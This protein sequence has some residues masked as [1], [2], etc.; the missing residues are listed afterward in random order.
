MT[1]R[2]FYYR[3]TQGIRVTVK[4]SY[5][6]SES[7]PDLGRYV[8][9]YHVRIENVSRHTVQLL[10]RRWLIADSIGEQTEVQGEGVVGQQPTLRPGMVHEYQSFCVLK[11]PEGHMEGQYFFRRDDGARFAAEIPRFHLNAA[12]IGP[13]H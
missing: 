8:F 13:V 6:A 3:M 5:L 1:S 11:S 4:P 10:A 2:A 9:A 7:R 12:G